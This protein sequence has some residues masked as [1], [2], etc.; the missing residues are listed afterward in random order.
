MRQNTFAVGA[1]S[2]TPLVEL[3]ALTKTPSC[4]WGKGVG[5]NWWEGLWIGKGGD[6]K[7]RKGREKRREREESGRTNSREKIL[8]TALDTAVKYSRSPSN[9]FWTSAGRSAIYCR[10]SNA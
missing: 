4:I 7:R 5:R 8:A 9:C 10:G 2:R 6:R 1:P 3:T